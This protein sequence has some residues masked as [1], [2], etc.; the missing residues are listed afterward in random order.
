MKG[1]LEIAKLLI[2]NGVIVYDIN[3]NGDAPLYIAVEN[4]HLEIVKFL[5]ENNVKNNVETIIRKEI[6]NKKLSKEI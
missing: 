3:Y 5:I 4:E 6:K 2:E 1:H